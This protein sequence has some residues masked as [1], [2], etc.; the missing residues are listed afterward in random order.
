MPDVITTQKRLTQITVALKAFLD[1][2]KDLREPRG[3]FSFGE[4]ERQQKVFLTAI[5]LEAALVD[6]GLADLPQDLQQT[7]NTIHQAFRIL[8]DA[9]GFR[10]YVIPKQNNEQDG[11]RKLRTIG[12]AVDEHGS[13]GL[14]EGSP[15]LAPYPL[16]ERIDP[17]K[18]PIFGRSGILEPYTFGPDQ[19][20]LVKML[21]SFVPDLVTLAK[22]PT[23][24]CPLCGGPK[25]IDERDR[26]TCRTCRTRPPQGSLGQPFQDLLAW[27]RDECEPSVASRQS[28]GGTVAYTRYAGLPIKTSIIASIRIFP[29]PTS[30]RITGVN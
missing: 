13:W 4:P 14:A 19:V 16:A 29:K 22:E 25:T 10:H 3:H 11:E 1:A 27:F 26:W 15:G 6:A 17:A 30:G 2:I 21:A 23:T 7:M 28:S 20:E 24:V 18:P 5:A 8:T 9:W 12:I